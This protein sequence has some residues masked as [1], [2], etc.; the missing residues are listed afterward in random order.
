MQWLI[1]SLICVFSK[2][3]GYQTQNSLILHYHRKK[4]SWR[5]EVKQQTHIFH[6]HKQINP[7][8]YE[9]IIILTINTLEI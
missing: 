5:L 6:Q 7:L 8:S 4:V 9:V 3:G 1:L 2:Y